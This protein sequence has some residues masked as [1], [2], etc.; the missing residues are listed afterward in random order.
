VLHALDQILGVILY[1][2]LLIGCPYGIILLLA[3]AVD[4]WL[5]GRHAPVIGLALFFVFLCIGVPASLFLAEQLR[6]LPTQ[7]FPTTASGILGRLHGAVADLATGYGTLKDVYELISLP[8]TIY[9][10]WKGRRFIF[11]WIPRR[12]A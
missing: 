10:A 8:A 2:G 9:G 6:L 7:G 5:P 12:P 3:M 1:F 4:H 11:R